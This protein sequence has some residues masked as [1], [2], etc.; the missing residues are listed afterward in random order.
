MRIAVYSRKS[1]WTGKG[2]SIENQVEM[3]RQ[4]IESRIEGGKEAEVFIYEDE[5]FSGKNLDRPQFQ[6]LLAD[7]KKQ[8]F[9]YI[10]CYRPVSYTHLR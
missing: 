9:N 2:E 7:S 8:K 1:V 10:V 5:G 4:Y 6:K 3:C